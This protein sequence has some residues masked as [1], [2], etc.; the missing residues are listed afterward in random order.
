MAWSLAFGQLLSWGTLYYS[1]TILSAPIHSSTGWSREF[2]NGG[3][4]WGLLMW[5]VFTVPAGSWVQ[6]QG[7]RTMM[8][9]ASISGGLALVSMGLVVHPV[10]YVA[11]WTV[12]GISMAGLLYDPAFA[13]VTTAFRSHYRRGITLI[14]LLGGLASTV[15]IPLTHLLVQSLGWRRSAI[16]LGACHIVLGAIIHARAVPGGPPKTAPHPSPCTI[17]PALRF[18][19]WWRRLRHEA[20]DRTFLA[21]ALWFSAHTAAFSGLTFLLVPLHQSTSVDPNDLIAAITLIGPMQVL[22]RLCLAFNGGKFSA[23]N[24]GMWAMASVISAALVLIAR[25]NGFYGLALFAMLYGIGN[26]VM[27]ILKGTVVAELFGRD[28]YAELNGLLAAPAVIAQAAAPLVLTALWTSTA[29]P[30]SV[31]AAVLLLWL[32]SLSGLLLARVRRA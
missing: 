7:G 17:S 1:F 24:T 3:L 32:A 9:T 18:F 5:G 29:S 20:G 22:G 19:A 10:A 30:A 31:T 4:S 25:P 14:T 16:V 12:L 21:L 6:R 13:V 23:L 11:A 28:R 8:T 26:G 15:Y 2:V 27:T